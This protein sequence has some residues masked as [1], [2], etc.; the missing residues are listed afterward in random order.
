MS[1]KSPD[2]KSAPS[3]PAPEA[4]ATP[5]EEADNDKKPAEEM[6][7]DQEEDLPAATIGQFLLF[8]PEDP[9]EVEFRPFGS[10]IPA[11]GRGIPWR[12]TGPDGL[13]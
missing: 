5:D 9:I 6:E 12:I 13:D 2:D 1:A 3:T 8:G 4:K 7:A 11:P 10:K